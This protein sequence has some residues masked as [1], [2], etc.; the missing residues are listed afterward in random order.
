[1]GNVVTRYG[2]VPT[3]WRGVFVDA[4]HRADAFTAVQ[5]LRDTIVESDVRAKLWELRGN[6]LEDLDTQ[7]R[8]RKALKLRLRDLDLVLDQYSPAPP[9]DLRRLVDERDRIREELPRPA[10]APEARPYFE[11]RMRDLE[12]LRVPRDLALRMARGVGVKLRGK[13]PKPLPPLSR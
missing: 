6:Y 1:M 13:A 3:E 5:Y 8:Y 2:R 9:G 4:R 11:A 12:T 7:S 10:H